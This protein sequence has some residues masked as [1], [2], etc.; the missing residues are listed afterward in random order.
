[1]RE[2]SELDRVRRSLMTRTKSAGRRNGSRSSWDT[3]S[4]GCAGCWSNPDRRSVTKR[5]QTL[6]RIDCGHASRIWQ[7]TMGGMATDA[8]PPWCAVKGS[9]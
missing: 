5:Q 2:P 4:V 7:A 3:R 8:L 6:R 9:V 1:V